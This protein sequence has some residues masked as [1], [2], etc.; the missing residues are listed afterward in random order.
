[1][2]VNINFYNYYFLETA[3]KI[4]MLS[5]AEKRIQK[6]LV[7]FWRC[8]KFVK[9]GILNY[10]KWIIIQGLFLYYMHN[11][12]T[13]EFPLHVQDLQRMFENHVL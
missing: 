2:N 10:F 4:I 1:M 11:H 5:L 13:C 8:T 9:A 12:N 3:V 7:A 6:H